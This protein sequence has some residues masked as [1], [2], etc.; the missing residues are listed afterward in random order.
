MMVREP[1]ER[2]P[3]KFTDKAPSKGLTSLPPEILFHI[4]PYIAYPD[5]FRLKL[6]GSRYIA[7]IISTFPR[8]SYKTYLTELDTFTSRLWKFD[9]GIRKA[10]EI[11]CEDGYDALVLKLLHDEPDF[12]HLLKTW[13]CGEKGLIAAIIYHQE[14]VLRVILEHIR[15]DPYL[16]RE[17]DY[18]KEEL[19]SIALYHAAASGDEQIF[20]LL[21]NQGANTR[22]GTS[23]IYEVVCGGHQRVMK[24]LSKGLFFHGGR[25]LSSPLIGAAENGHEA[26]VRFLLKKGAKTSSDPLCPGAIHMAA[27][28][29][30]E[31]I[32][33]LLHSKGARDS[34]VASRIVKK[35]SNREDT[36][37]NWCC[38]H[39][40]IYGKQYNFVKYLLEL[41]IMP[42][43]PNHYRATALPLAAMSGCTD[44]VKL[45]LETGFDVSA[46]LHGQS[47][48]ELA[49]TSGYTEIMTLLFDAGANI[50]MHALPLAARS[51]SVSAVSLLLGKGA[52]TESR[53]GDLNT[54]L[55][56]AVLGHHSE[57]VHLLLESGAKT[58]AASRGGQ[59]PLADAIQENKVDCVSLLLEYGAGTESK[60]AAEI[61][62]VVGTRSALSYAIVWKRAHLVPLL[63]QYGANIESEGYQRQR[64]LHEA[65]IQ[66][67]S[68]ILQIL[69][70]AGAD[71]QAREDF[72]MT[73]LHYAAS[74]SFIL[75]I[76]TLLS[77]GADIHAKN[78]RGQTPLHLA[79]YKA[80]SPAYEFLVS[81][82]ADEA[83]EDDEGIT[84][85]RY[86][87]RYG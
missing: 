60:H 43:D 33:R 4:V 24:M 30:Y 56:L 83:A 48:L 50:T 15:T 14:S 45:L 64:P 73:P 29:G 71:I 23:A 67:D 32:F 53:D 42:R 40:A 35:R 16:S 21:L 74:N 2:N 79:R 87:N 62:R 52:D 69:L 77:W 82:G 85:A 65:A 78:A 57:I 47:A 39:F 61:G 54:P 37:E 18:L 20:R 19:M 55:H 28:G 58:E 34:F 41:R 9:T 5:R 80:H 72:Q 63:L 25:K 31:S 59:T 3:R 84:P 8:P 22:R 1:T 12:R 13:S 36:Y 70:S 26:M 66:G 86:K 27:K 49:A 68:D 38:L 46:S 10:F 17:P 44:I 76:S 75:A 6:A 81:H 7:D 51:G 11:A